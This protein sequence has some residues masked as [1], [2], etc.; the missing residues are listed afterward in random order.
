[1]TAGP[2]EDPGWPGEEGKHFRRAGW[3]RASGSPDATQ[4]TPERGK[5]IGV[6]KQYLKKKLA[7]QIQ[8]LLTQVFI[9]GI[10]FPG[11]LSPSV[12]C[13]S[14]LTPAGTFLLSE[15][16]KRK[17]II[18]INFTKQEV[19]DRLQAWVAFLQFLPCWSC[20]PFFNLL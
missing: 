15:A 7:G 17:W 3:P 19:S 11:L 2:R 5:R 18:H 9:G 14:Q 12:L 4:H 1:M 13:K 16:T 8:H 20:L 10:I 6:C